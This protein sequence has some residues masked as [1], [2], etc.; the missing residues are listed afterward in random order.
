MANLYNFMDG[1]DGTGR[2]PGHFFIDRY[3]RMVPSL[4]RCRNGT[5][6]FGARRGWN[7]ISHPQLVPCACVPRGCRQL[8]AGCCFR[9]AGASWRCKVPDASERISAAVRRIPV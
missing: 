1:V 9:F 3:R 8:D 4:R 5:V 7:W 6:L 2:E